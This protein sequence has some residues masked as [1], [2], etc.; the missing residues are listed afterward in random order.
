MNFVSGKQL[1]KM[2]KVGQ[3]TWEGVS[4]QGDVVVYRV[5]TNLCI[6]SLNH[7]VM[8]LAKDLCPFHFLLK[9]EKEH[10]FIFKNF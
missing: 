9:V 7:Q 8:L 4:K 2:G 6:D 1:P 10:Y 3:E 5:R